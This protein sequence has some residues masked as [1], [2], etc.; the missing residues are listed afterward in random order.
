[1]NTVI[2][3]IGNGDVILLTDNDATAAQTVEAL[4]VLIDR[5]HE[6]GYELVTLS[7]LIAADKDLKDVVDLTRAGLPKDA[8]L[9]VI[10]D[11]AESSDEEG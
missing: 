1:M 11:D 10:E 6:E 9:P 7:E 4:P 2:G 3:S 5:L 8:V